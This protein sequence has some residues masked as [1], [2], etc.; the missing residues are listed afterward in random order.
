MLEPL[1]E[2]ALAETCAPF[3]PLWET[4]RTSTEKITAEFNPKLTALQQQYGKSLEALKSTV[5]KRGDLVKTK[6]VVTEMER[7][8]NEKIVPTEP[9]E[10]EIAEITTVQ[11]NYL[12][13]LAAVE[14]DMGAR[15]GNLTKRY[16][17]A[18]EQLQAD[19]VRT[20]KL[21]DATAVNEALERAR[22]K[23]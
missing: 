11:A 19:L 7:F 1:D 17:Q 10:T 8:E 23:F 22:K 20:D 6:A 12:K 21:D 16:A 18:L 15:M 4:Y 3:K 13:A 2:G 14:K 5:Q 9:D